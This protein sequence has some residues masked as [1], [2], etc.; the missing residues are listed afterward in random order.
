MLRQDALAERFTLHEL[1]RFNATQ[2]ASGE[3]ESADPAEGVDHAEHVP[4]LSHA[5]SRPL[6]RSCRHPRPSHASQQQPPSASTAARMVGISA[7]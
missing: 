6:Q 2:P 3:G 4:S 1:H 7:D 5:S